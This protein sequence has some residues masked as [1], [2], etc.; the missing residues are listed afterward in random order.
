MVL[1]AIISLLD[2]S[3][4]LL[5]LLVLLLLLLLLLGRRGCVVGFALLLL[6]LTLSVDLLLTLQRS[7]IVGCKKR[8]TME[9]LKLSKQNHMTTYCIPC[10]RL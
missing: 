7:L 8:Y 5:L 4:M 3:A 9:L 6:L 2:G 1:I 10:T